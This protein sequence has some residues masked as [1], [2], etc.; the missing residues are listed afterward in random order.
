MHGVCH[1]I[2]HR[3]EHISPEIEKHTWNK[4]SDNSFLPA[5]INYIAA[6]VII[7]IS[8]IGIFYRGVSGFTVVLTIRVFTVMRIQMKNPSLSSK[9]NILRMKKLLCV[10]WNLDVVNNITWDFLR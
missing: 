5:I 6:G 1:K 2:I 3:Q 4:R 10:P 8:S 9:Y 7:S